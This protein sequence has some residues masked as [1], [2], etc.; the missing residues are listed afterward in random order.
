MTPAGVRQHL[1]TLSDEGLVTS[2]EVPRPEGERGR[3]RQRYA[4]SARSE[5]LFPKAYDELANE[6]LRHAA[7]E[8]GT[9]IERIFVRRRDGRIDNARRRLDHQARACEAKVAELATHPRRGRLPGRV[10]GARR[11]ALP[12][13]PSTTAPSWPWPATT[14][15]P[16]AARSSSCRRC[17]PRPPSSGCRTSWPAPTSA[18][19]WSRRRLDEASADRSGP[20]RA[21]PAESSGRLELRPVGAVEHRFEG[22]AV[23][24]RSSGSSGISASP[25]WIDRCCTRLMT[26]PWRSAAYIT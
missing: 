17:C 8:D 2:H 21:P 14:P 18:P 1:A 16:A 23:H 24:D 19:T 3:P 25:K 26:M 5:P 12:A 22:G 6:L 9:L 11:R 20:A 4:L 15:T 10:G 13:S 7:D